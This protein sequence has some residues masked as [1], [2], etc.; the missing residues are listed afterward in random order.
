MIRTEGSRKVLRNVSWLFVER[1]V[2]LAVV[3]LTG[4]YVARGLG[5]EL[6]GHLN[7]ATGFVGLFFALGAM[8][9]D[10]ILV[11]DLVKHPERRAELL[12]TGA[13]IK[14]AGAAL[15]VLLATLGSLLKGMDALTVSLVVVIASAELLRPFGVIEQ[16]FMS[17]VKA[18]PVVR[19][20][21]AQVLVSSGV[22]FA[23]L[24]LIH[25]GVLTAREALIGFAW[26]YVI[27]SVVLTLGYLLA[28]QRWGGSWR[29]WRASRSMARHLLRE[30]WPMLIYGMALFVQARIDQVMIKDMLAAR[31]GEAAAYAEVGQYSV[32]LRM[33]EALGFLPVIVQAS[34]AP[35]ITRA[36]G[37]SHAMYTDRLLNQYRLMFL[38]FLVTAVPLYFLARPII[39][40]LFGAEYEPAGVL[41]SL[42]AI[43]L[44]FT[45]MG[46][47]KR[48]F[49]TNESL[50][51][52]SLFTAAV[53]VLVNVGINWLL[54]PDLRSI[55]AIWA[56]IISFLVSI[57][58]LDLLFP[59]TRENL[60]LMVTGILTF[61]RFHRAA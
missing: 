16:W 14:L 1:L 45:N 7:Y 26:V 52:Y 30:S 21:M 18:G 8:G 58:L 56:T 51:R 43:R 33:I 53:G 22:K 41:L 48:S 11:R 42:F 23:L 60:R 19:V 37:V 4:I 25:A 12:G 35:A 5:E 29:T 49:I 47:G 57:F 54:I 24:G 2:R 39:V 20:Q 44:F 61:W 27:E 28:L 55:G 46:T 50:F 6:F 9:I 59:R 3:L 13:L 34:L 40:L 10:E 38:L 31:E 15:L 17:Q 36:K 32:A